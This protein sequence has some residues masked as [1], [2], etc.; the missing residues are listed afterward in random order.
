M[1][2]WVAGRGAER[3][4]EVIPPMAEMIKSKFSSNGNTPKAATAARRLA[5]RPRRPER[6]EEQTSE[7]NRI[8]IQR[9]LNMI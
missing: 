9:T 5:A 6:S 7:I 3:A 8:M 4:G 2:S 1:I